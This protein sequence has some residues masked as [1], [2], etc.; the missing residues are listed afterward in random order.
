[1]GARAVEDS[2]N[3]RPDPGFVAILAFRQSS[4]ALPMISSVQPICSSVALS[5]VSSL[6][7]WRCASRPRWMVSG[8]VAS[9]SIHGH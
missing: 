2:P 7:A 6:D 8:Q 3:S 4:S 5:M 9:T 1:M